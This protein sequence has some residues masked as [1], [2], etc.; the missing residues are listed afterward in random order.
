MHT[1]TLKSTFL[2]RAYSLYISALFI[3][4]QFQIMDMKLHVF[5]LL[6][7]LVI[8]ADAVDDGKALKNQA[9]KKR[10]RRT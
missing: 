8:N 6:T 7:I 10:K 2:F 5:I 1:L 4:L 3:V 9:N